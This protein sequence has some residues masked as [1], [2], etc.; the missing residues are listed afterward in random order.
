MRHPV[1]FTFLGFYFNSLVDSGEFLDIKETHSKIQNKELFNWLKAKYSDRL[2][3]SLFNK[4]QLNE[5]EDFFE[6][7]SIATDEKRKMGIEKNG[8]CLLV[9]YCIEAAQREEKDL[10]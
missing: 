4:E 5:I 6:S 8:L 1:K 7:L 2:D 3:I 10:R 9:A